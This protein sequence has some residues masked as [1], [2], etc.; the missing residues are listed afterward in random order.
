MWRR[1]SCLLRPD[2]S[3]RFA[4]TTQGSAGVPSRQAESL[5]HVIRV[6]L[7]AFLLLP[8]L[9]GY[10]QEAGTGAPSAEMRDAVASLQRGDFQGAERKLRAEIAAHPDDAWAL[11]LLGSALDNLKRIPE[12]DALHRQAI[13]KSPRSTEILN[14]YAAHLWLSGDEREAAKVYRQVVALDPAHFNANL[15]LARLALKERNPA[16][17]LQCLDRLPPGRQENPQVLLPRLEALYLSGDRGRAD[18]LAARL[19]E[20]A[21]ADASLSFAAGMVLSNVEQFARAET[22]FESALAHDPANFNVLYDLGIAATR[23][24]HQDRA[25]Q[26]LEAALR[27]QPQNVDVLYGLACVDHALKQ[28]ETAI[29]LLSQAAR[30]DP[31]RADVQKMLAVATGD[32]G[33]LD[34]AAAAW[35]RYLKLAPNDDIARRERGYTAAQ[36]GQFEDGIADL[37]WYAAKHPG[38]VAGHYELGQAERTVDMA[39]AIEQF[40]RALSLDPKYV[41][42]LTARGSLYYQQG[43][44]EE[45]EKDLEAAAAL[46]PDDAD[47]LDRLGQAYQALNRTA[48]AVETLRRAAKLA[49][50]DSK[51]LLHFARALA[52]AGNTEE[53][54]AVMD[55]FRQLGPEKKTGVRAGFVEYLSLTDEQR[56]ADYRARLEKAIRNHPEDA[57]LRVDY[58]KLLLGD[59]DLEQV[60]TVARAIAGIEAAPAVLADAGR[61]L[62]AAKQYALASELLQKAEEAGPQSAARAAIEL[63]LSVTT[64]RLGDPAKGLE[65]LDRMPESA[66]NGEYYLS[67]AEMLDASGHSAEARRALEQALRTDPQRPDLYR[68]AAA[69]LLARGQTADALQLLDGAARTLPQNRGI[70]LLGAAAA[71]LAGK[72]GEAAHSLS[73]IQN[74]WPEWP[75]AWAAQGMILAIHRHC[76]EGRKALETAVRLGAPGPEV[77]YYLAD[78]ALRSGGDG[79]DAAESA[80][81]QALELSREDPW[82]QALAGEI[83]LEKGNSALAVERLREAIRLRPDSVPAHRDLAR[84]YRALGRSKEAQAELEEA[85]KLEKNSTDAGGAPGYLLR[86]FFAAP[87]DHFSGQ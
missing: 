5:R 39:K 56:H 41:P 38:D 27:Q 86:L 67:R 73:E 7:T 13:A 70:L 66:R 29:H 9:N 40:D 20:M 43:K 76:E 36:R 87:I 60:P 47:S 18:R 3:G 10:P 62:V 59:G 15:Q 46:R 74:R 17:A 33:A 31:R 65:R 44:P 34:D 37:E 64:F 80:I 23:A 58:L 24:G 2:S 75:A 55:R 4:R 69:L 30:L 45:A 8:G 50:G 61:A 28:F 49:P 21:R 79:K 48:E 16:E 25:R 11:S 83:A 1:H 32:L 26:A 19:S 6:S 51:I 72:T 35:D 84:A 68:R 82:I 14:N 54:K 57:A 63:D 52:T 53:S 78:C 77:Y 81:A 42:A 12:A 85:G 22:F 71:E